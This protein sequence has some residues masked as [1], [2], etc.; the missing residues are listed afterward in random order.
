MAIIGKNVIE[1]LTLGMYENSLMIYREYIQKAADS[2]DKA[3]NLGIL[4]EKQDQYTVQNTTDL[5]DK[6][7]AQIDIYI[8]QKKRTISIYDNALGIPKDKFYNILSSIADS[9]KDKES[10]KGFRGIGRLA[11]LAYC[12]KLIFTSS[13]I[14]ENKKSIMIWDG[15]LLKNILNDT[16]NRI[17][18]SDLVDKVIDYKTEDCDINEHFFEVILNDIST[19]NNELLNVK[20]VCDYLSFVAP[21]PY[22]KSFIY[23]SKIYD[24]I[25]ENN[26]KLDEYDI[27]VNGNPL[28][29]PYKTHL[30]SKGKTYDEIKDIEFKLI[31]SEDNKLLGWMWFAVIKFVINIPK[32][33]KMRSIRLRKE[34]IQIGNE[35]TLS[36]FFKEARGSTYF[37]GEVMA[38]D[39]NLIPNAR[40]DYFNINET[41]REFEK[42]LI[43]ILNG[44]AYSL[45]HY[46][47]KVKISFRK[48]Y[49]IIE[50][51]NEFNLK[52]QQGEF[53]DKNDEINAKKE[54]EK[55]EENLSSLTNSIDK[56]E[57]KYKENNLYNKV[58]N[59]IKE[60]F[61]KK[62]I[63]S[64]AA[65]FSQQNT[66][67]TD[68]ISKNDNEN[69]T[70]TEQE[71]SNKKKKYKAQELSKYNKREQKL[72]TRIYNKIRK[73]LAKDMA[74]D[75]INKIQEDLKS[76]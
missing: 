39:K 67:K 58:F 20:D 37:I 50:K 54:L 9:E 74:E 35:T 49:D 72:I 36:K 46:A 18:A 29:K 30:L 13:Y 68:S 31:H 17:S 71:K 16:K 19:E 40:R 32:E 60:D 24:F 73:V 76:E 8:D 65:K 6:E 69:N 10:N 61:Q 21:V 62:D 22:A 48:Q 2:I 3:I 47:N 14:G 57:N 11:G 44:E 12:K 33:N 66:I 15:E 26:L 75:L 25:K 27:L 28:F 59:L 1:N 70:H 51:E 23:R 38:I 55:E 52:V 43:P 7:K 56:L 45:Y 53:F 5:D 4:K 63:E 34:N 64:N 41:L 42:A